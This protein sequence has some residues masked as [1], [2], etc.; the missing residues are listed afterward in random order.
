MNE[1]SEYYKNEVF[2]YFKEFI[3]KLP[4]FK[5]IEQQN[6]EKNN[7][8]EKIDQFYIKEKEMKLL[9]NEN[10]EL[11]SQLNKLKT[12]NEKYKNQCL[13]HNQRII[14]FIM[15]MTKNM[16]MMKKEIHVEKKGI[17][18]IWNSSLNLQ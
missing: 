11:K 7:N 12:N 8:Q 1:K 15:A 13:F 6:F 3:C 5:M 9:K 16:K 18:M 4:L 10:E 2:T 17:L 14:L